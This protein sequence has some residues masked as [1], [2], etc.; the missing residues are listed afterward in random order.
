MGAGGLAP[1]GFR[2][3]IR[4]WIPPLLTSRPLEWKAGWRYLASGTESAR[5]FCA[6]GARRCP[7]IP[8]AT[9]AATSTAADETSVEAAIRVAIQSAAASAAA[10]ADAAA[11]IRRARASVPLAQANIVKH[12]KWMAGSGDV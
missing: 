11:A 10:A 1:Y 9:T 4:L 2:I 5:P 7:P 6:P 8:A 12:V 3:R